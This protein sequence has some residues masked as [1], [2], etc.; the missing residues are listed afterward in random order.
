MCSNLGCVA[1]R[2]QVKGH[3]ETLKTATA[4]PAAL[5]PE[6]RIV[7]SNQNFV[8]TQLEKQQLLMK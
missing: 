5:P 4:A 6:N 3:K 1:L 2:R 8:D 7:T